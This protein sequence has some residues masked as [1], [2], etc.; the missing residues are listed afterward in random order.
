MSSIRRTAFARTPRGKPGGAVAPAQTQIN[1]KFLDQITQARVTPDMATVLTKTAA[2]LAITIQANGKG[3][4]TINSGDQVI[5]D[6]SDVQKVQSLGTFINDERKAIL[7]TSVSSIAKKTLAA[8]VQVSTDPAF[9]DQ[10]PRPITRIDKSFVD[11]YRAVN[12]QAEMLNVN[13]QQIVQTNPVG[14]ANEMVRNHFIETGAR[15]RVAL[16]EYLLYRG[17]IAEG[18]QPIKLNEFLTRKL[19]LGWVF[20]RL[21]DQ[22]MQLVGKDFEFRKV[23]F[24]KDPT[25]G[26]Q[27][28]FRELKSAE[29]LG[30]QGGVLGSMSV[31]RGLWSDDS[32]RAICGI[33]PEWDLNNFDGPSNV[34]MNVPFLVVPSFHAVTLEEHFSVLAQNGDRG[35]PWNVGNTMTPQDTMRFLGTI[36]KKISYG[37]IGMP[38]FC[39]PWYENLFPGF[40]FDL[41][42][43]ERA[44]RSVFNQLMTQFRAGQIGTTF[45]ADVCGENGYATARTTVPPLVLAVMDMPSDN[46]LSRET[47]QRITTGM[48]AIANG[49]TQPAADAW[50]AIATRRNMSDE[51]CNSLLNGILSVNLEPRNKDA[52]TGDIRTARCG[53]SPEGSSLVREFKR[54]GYQALAVRI[55]QWLRSFLTTRLQAAVAD[56]ISARLEASLATPVQFGRGD[57]AVF[58]EPAE[59]AD[60]AAADDEPPGQDPEDDDAPPSGDVDNPDDH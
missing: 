56:V 23:Y 16:G 14:S 51:R 10:V 25:K 35:L 41:A 20:T 39:A 32:V 5:G 15:I 47:I 7:K 8:V 13:M 58:L 38:R 49:E 57:T 28:T 60:S 24:P 34:L 12:A 21:C 48:I 18:D 50:A 31:F 2:A 17:G 4:F 11:V 37:F 6:S 19:V 59:F 27:I 26:L 45:F 53:I 43:T 55:D 44:D 52:R 54:R 9:L 30:N 40:T 33:P 42:A 36:P 29:L 46:V 1:K 22:K 3:N